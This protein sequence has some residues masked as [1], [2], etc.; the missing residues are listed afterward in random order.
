MGFFYGLDP[1]YWLLI[2][3]TM[4]LALWAQIKVKSNF[5][6]YSQVT[7]ANRLSGAEAAE[8]VL[9]YANIHNV[10]IE[11]VGGMLSDHYD[12][13]TKTLRLSPDVFSGRS[14]AA[15]G[16]AAHEAGHAIQHA[17]G[18]VPLKLRSAMVPMA[19]FGSW[20]AWPMILFGMLLNSLH[21]MQFGVI[22]FTALVAF[23]LITLPVEFNASSRAKL[24]LVKAG[25]L[26]NQQ[27]AEGVDRVLNAAAM[28]YV[29]ATITAVA[30]LLYFAMRAGLLGG[31]RD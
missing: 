12:P 21:L 19:S 24:V 16:V 29:A 4:I 30:Q 7:T 25:V 13:R 2:G 26:V 5:A 17:A 1:L 27:E 20:L 8:T 28:T 18:Y 15:A 9:R 31:R 22:A 11:E 23:Q 10:K 6:R 3:P 14:I